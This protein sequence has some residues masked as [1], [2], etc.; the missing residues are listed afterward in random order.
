M[1]PSPP[2]TTPQMLENGDLINIAA[3]FLKEA[4]KLSDYAPLIDNQF[5]K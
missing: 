3:G 2:L 5:T 4:D 1:T